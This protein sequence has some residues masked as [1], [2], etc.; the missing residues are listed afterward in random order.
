MF[1]VDFSPVRVLVLSFGSRFPP[2]FS[3]VLLF[4]LSVITAMDEGFLSPFRLFSPFFPCFKVSIEEGGTNFDPESVLRFWFGDDDTA[5]DNDKSGDAL[6]NAD[7]PDHKS[8]V[9]CGRGR[10]DAL[11]CFH[12]LWFASLETQVC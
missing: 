4:F 12:S 8:K 5:E 11:S 6:S 9:K 10:R 3:F 2:L 7:H 1:V